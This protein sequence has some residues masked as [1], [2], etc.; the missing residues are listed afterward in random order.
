MVEF[1]LSAF[2]VGLVIGI[3]PVED[4][5]YEGGGIARG[6]ADQRKRLRQ[7]LLQDGLGGVN[8]ELPLEVHNLPA[9]GATA[10]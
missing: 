3:D 7:D 4:G 10:E 2:D 5:I 9:R 8:I 6:D 1:G